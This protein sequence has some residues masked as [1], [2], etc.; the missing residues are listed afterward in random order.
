MF[1]FNSLLPSLFISNL[2]HLFHETCVVAVHIGL[3]C[4]GKYIFEI[5]INIFYHKSEKKM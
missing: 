5:M 4:E 1:I 3:S 2:F